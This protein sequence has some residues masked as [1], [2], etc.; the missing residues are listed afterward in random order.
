[1]YEEC[2]R[3]SDA[4]LHHSRSMYALDHTE[5]LLSHPKDSTPDLQWSGV[6]YRIPCSNCPA[7]YIRQTGRRLQQRIEEHKHAVRQ[8]DFNSSVLAEHAWNHSHPV[9]WSNVEILSNPRDTV[10]RL[11]EEAVAIR[12]TKGTLNRDTSTL[13][14][15]YDNLF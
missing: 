14:T 15:E 10:T 1:M 7:S 4:S 8:A 2:L 6:V 12:K 5:Q 13:P 9:N 11:V 3:H